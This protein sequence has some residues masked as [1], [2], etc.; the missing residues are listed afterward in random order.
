MSAADALMRA[1]AI[2]DWREAGECPA[3]RKITT[4]AVAETCERQGCPVGFVGD[5]RRA[6]LKKAAHA[7]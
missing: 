1:C 3:C 4:A 6:R 5:D 7:P 2:I